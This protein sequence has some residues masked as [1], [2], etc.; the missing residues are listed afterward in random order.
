MWNYG[1]LPLQFQLQPLKTCSLSRSNCYSAIIIFMRSSSNPFTVSMG[2]RDD[3]GA[4]DHLAGRQSGRMGGRMG[5]TINNRSLSL[6]RRLVTH[7]DRYLVWLQAYSGPL[8]L[9]KKGTHIWRPHWKGPQEA[10]N[11]MKNPLICVRDKEED[12]AN[13][14]KN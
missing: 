13:K 11:W 9:M 6:H 8:Y 7:R 12:E 1:Q 5:L 3:W 10:D 2:L 4:R 14:S